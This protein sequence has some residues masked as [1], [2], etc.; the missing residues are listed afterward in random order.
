MSYSP[1]LAADLPHRGRCAGTDFSSYRDAWRLVWQIVDMGR[2]MGN[3]NPVRWFSYTYSSYVS[4]VLFR[5]LINRK[6]WLDPLSNVMGGWW[7]WTTG[8]DGNQA[9]IGIQID[10]VHGYY[11]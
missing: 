9:L 7:I 10:F 1:G 3:K 5:T 6:F 2:C 4:M 11:I 8:I